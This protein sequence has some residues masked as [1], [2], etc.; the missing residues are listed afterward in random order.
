MDGNPFKPFGG[1]T[2]P[3][4][5]GR[6]DELTALVNGAKG[7]AS[8]SCAEVRVM[9]A[10]RGYGKTVLL[11]EFERRLASDRPSLFRLPR[12][13]GPL[14]ELMPDGWRDPARSL[15]VLS[16]RAAQMKT[17]KDLLTVLSSPV[18]G[19]TVERTGDTFTITGV[20]TKG[21]QQSFEVEATTATMCLLASQPTVLIVDE[22]SALRPDAAQTLLNA[23]ES[24]NRWGEHVML[25]IAGTPGLEHALNRASATFWDRADHMRMKRLDDM[26]SR[27][28]ILEPL[29]DCGI[30]IDDDALNDA[31]GLT[32]G[33]PHFLQ[34][35]GRALYDHAHITGSRRLSQE[36]IDATLSTFERERNGL[37]ARRVKEMDTELRA[38]ALGVAQAFREA[39]D[40]QPLPLPAIHAA[41]T[42][43]FREAGIEKT[44]DDAYRQLTHLG[45][46]WCP[47]D[48]AA[49][50]H[51]PGIPSLM[52][53][54]VRA[55]NMS[56]E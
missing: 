44:G 50:D 31:V 36:S 35:W 19:R 13:P 16:I 8:G 9:M 51:G 1:Q 21:R 28:A 56:S 4:L 26:A 45:F 15:R 53:Y 18:T 42:D 46:F 2:P 49:L 52:D 12:L 34:L 17:P 29:R 24:V 20:G 5:A 14:Q 27:Q 41:I 37:Y 3:C 32:H 48:D 43:G 38:A 7:L 55:A 25:I 23:V 54:V 33:Y 10:P 30:E 39:G 11:T 6:D 22:G 47:D 40:D